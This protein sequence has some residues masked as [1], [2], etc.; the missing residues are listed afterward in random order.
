[1]RIALIS[2]IHFGYFSRTAEFSVPGEPIQDESKGGHSLESELKDL[3]KNNGVEYLFV[4]GDMTSK[5]SPQEFHY[6]EMKILDIAEHVGIPVENI[7]CSVGNHDID[8]KISNLAQE[9]F[10]DTSLPEVKRLTEDN[11]QYIAANAAELNLRRLN[12]LENGVVPSSGI[13]FSSDFIVF[14][15]NTSLLCSSNQ[16]IPHGKL[17]KEQLDWFDEKSQEYIQDER[18]KIV[19]MHH[20]PTNYAYHIHAFDVSMI[21]EGSELINIAG[22]NGIDIIMHG[23]RHHPT[24]VTKNEDGWLHPIAFLCAG[25]LSVNAK[26]RDNGEIPNTVHILEIDKTNKDMILFNYQ[27]TSAE[28]WKPVDKRTPAVPLDKEMWLGKLTNEKDIDDYLSN[29]KEGYH[30]F[31]WDELSKSLKYMNIEKLNKK[32][33]D[34]FP[35]HI[36]VGEFPSNVAIMPKMEV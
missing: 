8:R 18:I 9:S 32:I 6:C 35:N 3:L 34:F 27:F 17:T 7:V 4:A 15:L 24:A 13:Y 11:Y 21:E 5:G 20:H 16:K 2:D 23:H 12:K 29:Y 28:G 22:K 25:S 1:M 19:L 26:H 30:L 31:K 10:T 36:V 14:V 33:C